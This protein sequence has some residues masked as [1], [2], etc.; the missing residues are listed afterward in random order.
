MNSKFYKKIIFLIIIIIFVSCLLIYNL[1]NE[2]N[3]M[4]FEFIN[5]VISNVNEKYPDSE[6]DIINGIFNEGIK[7]DISSKYGINEYNNDFY[8]DNIS[9]TQRI[10]FLVVLFVSIITIVFIFFMVTYMI[11]QNKK[12]KQ[13]NKYAENILNSNYSLDIR[14]NEEGQL[15]I[16]KNKIYDMTIVLREKNIFLDENKKQIEKLI[17]DISHQLKTPLTS[18]NLIN[19]L[20][21]SDIPHDKKMQFLKDMSKELYKIEWQVKTL[22]NIAKL[23]SKTL[24][25][26]KDNVNIYDMCNKCKESFNVLC[27]I[28]NVNIDINADKNIFVICD[29]AWTMEAINNI[30]KNA[31]EHESKNI[32]IKID[33][34]RLYAQITIKDDGEGIDRSDIHYIFDRFHKSKNSKSGSLGLGLAFTKSILINQNGDIK[35]DSKKDSYTQFI[36]KLYY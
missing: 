27:E 29:E 23:D 33:N 28:K 7:S 16:L 17:A 10:I 31:I 1:N 5:Q 25:L 6:S 18:L 3:K 13:I 2:Y 22:L 15:S 14:D 34:T 4:R 20:L 11:K 32:S 21:Y 24:I 30:I 36:I 12:I 19:E 26:K 9:F 35:V 8:I